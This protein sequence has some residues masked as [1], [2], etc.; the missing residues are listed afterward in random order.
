[1]IEAEIGQRFR[2]LLNNGPEATQARRFSENE[3][4]QKL[5]GNEEIAN[6][7]IPKTFAVGC[8]RPTPGEGFLE[9]L[10]APNVT[11]HTQQ[12][13]RVVRHGFIANDGTKEEVDVIICATGFDTSWV[14][15]FPIKA[16][17]KN[18]QDVWTQEGPLSYLAV[19]VP[20]VPN[21]FSFAGPVSL[22]SISLLARCV[23]NGS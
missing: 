1:M 4:R 23:A 2:F 9:A 12:M 3:M 19:G 8:R 5:K 6:A 11:V 15:R 10:V 16:H 22:H 13:Q 14:T 18:L 17:G 20:D 7:I 21:L